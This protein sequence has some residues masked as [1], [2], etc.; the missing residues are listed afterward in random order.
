MPATFRGPHAT[1]EESTARTK[2]RDLVVACEGT[3]LQNDDDGP[4]PAIEPFDLRRIAHHVDATYENSVECRIR[5]RGTSD[6]K[7]RA[8]EARTEGGLHSGGRIASIACRCPYSFAV[9]RDSGRV[10]GVILS[11]PSFCATYFGGGVEMSPHVRGLW[12]LLV[13]VL[14]DACQ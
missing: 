13:L 10:A 14:R 11:F 3:S 4:S 6:L 2:R 5:V 12:G 1:Y 7:I 9:R 8:F